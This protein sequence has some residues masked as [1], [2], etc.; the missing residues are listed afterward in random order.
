LMGM[1]E[2]TGEQE[3]DRVAYRGNSKHVVVLPETT[4]KLIEFDFDGSDR[5]NW[6][7][8]DCVLVRVSS[9]TGNASET[10]PEAQANT[11]ARPAAANVGGVLSLSVGPAS[12]GSKV[13][14]RQLWVL[15]EDAQVALIKGGLT[16]TADASV[17][18]SWIRAC[19][20]K[21]PACEQGA[22]ALKVYSVGLVTTDADGRAQTPPLPAGRYWVL[23]DTKID[24]KRWMWNQPVDVK[25]AQTSLTLDQQNAIP[26]E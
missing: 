23:S 10:G 9:K 19:L 11:D 3:L 14:G 20:S 26:V 21:A 12:A 24:N 17:L 2:R 6:T 16:S 5:I 15:K 18:Q 1:D 7:G 4:L 13:A 25:G 22:R 8:Q